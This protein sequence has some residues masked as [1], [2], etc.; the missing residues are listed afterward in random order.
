VSGRIGTTRYLTYAGGVAGTECLVH[1]FLRCIHPK[2]ETAREDIWDRPDKDGKIKI[3]PAPAGQLLG[4]S[5]W[6]KPLA[7]WIMATGVGLLD[8]ELRDNEALRVERNDEWR[9]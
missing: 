3:Q 7:D 5:K 1:T 9:R 6:E 8:N 2:L 4:K